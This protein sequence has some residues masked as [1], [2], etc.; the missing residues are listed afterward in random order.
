MCQLGMNKLQTSRPYREAA[1]AFIFI[2]K[3][4]NNLQPFSP[5]I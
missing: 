3:A 4:S 5:A 2:L 1:E